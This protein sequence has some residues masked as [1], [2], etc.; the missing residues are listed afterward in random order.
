MPS[1]RAV[2]TLLPPQRR[3]A[4]KHSS[5][6]HLIGH[7]VEGAPVGGEGQLMRPCFVI[8]LTRGEC[9]VQRLAVG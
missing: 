2:A 9:H 8:H 6:N 7:I 5:L 4:S 1:M 3:N